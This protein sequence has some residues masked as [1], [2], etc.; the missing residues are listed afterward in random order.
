MKS[1]KLVCNLVALSALLTM[2]AHAA[3][4]PCQAGC[5][6]QMKACVQTARTTKLSCKMD[7]RTNSSPTDLGAC[8]RGC[9]TTFRSAKD[10]CRAGLQTCISGCQGGSADGAFTGSPT[11]TACADDCGQA[12]GTCAQGV[13]TTAKACA[14]DCR[15]TSDPRSCLQA[16]AS[17]AQSGGEACGASF[18]TC[19]AACSPTS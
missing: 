6:L 17:A 5:G 18:Q 11:D 15:G 13:V 19:L 2:P 9:T 12:L 1:W 3:T 10:T 16:C 4:Q 14:R 8:M 7:C